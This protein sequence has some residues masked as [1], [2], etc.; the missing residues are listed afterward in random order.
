[1]LALSAETA[2]VDSGLLEGALV[3]VASGLVTGIATYLLLL[4]RY[5][6]SGHDPTSNMSLANST[7][8]HLDEVL[9]ERAAAL[10]LRL[11]VGQAGV[12]PVRVRFSDGSEVFYFERDL[13]RYDR[14]LLGG[15]TP[16]DRSTIDDPPKLISTWTR[17]EKIRWLSDHPMKTDKSDAK[18]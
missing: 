17:S 3:M 4:R 7:A 5:R 2:L 10:G 9:T 16:L 6:G 15:I 11:P 8:D 14:Y 12:K 18:S 1:M 13:D